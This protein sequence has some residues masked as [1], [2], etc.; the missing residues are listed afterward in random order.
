MF[1]N[2]A[3]VN[4]MRTL[5]SDGFKSRLVNN[6]LNTHPTITLKKINTYTHSVPFHVLVVVV[7]LFLLA[8]PGHS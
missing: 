4:K 6:A 1:N 2:S 8:L 3:E 5:I 7:H